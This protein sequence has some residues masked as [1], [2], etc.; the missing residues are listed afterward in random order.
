MIIFDSL[1]VGCDEREKNHERK[2][3]VRTSQPS[4]GV[5]PPAAAKKEMPIAYYVVRGTYM[6][7]GRLFSTTKKRGENL[8]FDFFRCSFRRSYVTRVVCNTMYIQY[9][10]YPFLLLLVFLLLHLMEKVYCL[11]ESRTLN[12]FFAFEFDCIIFITMPPSH[13]HPFVRIAVYCERALSLQNLFS[14]A[15]LIAMCVCV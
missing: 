12:M 13:H 11:A 1:H 4:I 7:C 14:Y 2:K 15:R 8:V 9:F 5:P 6:T 10:F 3:C